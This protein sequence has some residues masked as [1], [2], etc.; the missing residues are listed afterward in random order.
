[1]FLKFLKQM[2]AQCEIERETRSVRD[3]EREMEWNSEGGGGKTTALIVNVELQR[4][5]KNF[6]WIKKWR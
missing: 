6:Q 2:G 1:M 5:Y 4:R 3:G